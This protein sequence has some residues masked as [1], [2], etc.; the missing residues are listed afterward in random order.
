MG[1]KVILFSLMH[2]DI[3][4]FENTS[5][6]SVAA[7]M[8]NNNCKVVMCKQK[9]QHIDYEYIKKE[10]PDIIGFSVEYCILNDVIKVAAGCKE[11]LE[12]VIIFTENT[13]S[14]YNY[15]MIMKSAP[16]L[17]FVIIGEPE[18]V[19]GDVLATICEN[20]AIAL[21]E[22]IAYREDNVIKTNENYSKCKNLD[23]LPFIARDLIKDDN[24]IATVYSSKGCTGNCTF[25]EK[26]H[27]NFE[28][29]GR[30]PQNFV[31]EIIQIEET[32]KPN[33]YM[34]SDCSFDDP[35]IYGNRITE[36]C[37]KIVENNLEIY[38]CT[39]FKATFHKKANDKLNELLLQSGL[40]AVLIGIESGNED[41][42]CLYNKDATVEDNKKVI[43]YFNSLNVLIIPSF[44]C[45]NP[46]S[47]QENLIKNLTFLKSI[48][49]CARF[50]TFLDVLEYTP[51][52]KKI[53]E[54]G[55]I[56]EKNKNEGNYSYNYNYND[57]AVHQYRFK[58]KEIGV[59]AE[60][61]KQVMANLNKNYNNVFD[62]Y[63]FYLEK[64]KMH[65]K[66]ILRKSLNHNRQNLVEEVEKHFK[67]LDT[68]H[69]EF[70]GFLYEW[71][72]QLTLSTSEGVIISDLESIT[73]S[74]GISKR[75]ENIVNALNAERNKVVRK[76][77]RLD[78]KLIEQWI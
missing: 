21:I 33:I 78:K 4:M 29:R 30:S 39:S 51:I 23:E 28:W 17:D 71:L 12:N 63:L 50:L 76:I 57:N 24:K 18:M 40:I 72:E 61:L 27:F 36:I 62:D 9:A 43:E 8:R 54:A 26:K 11:I 49:Q 48:K 65:M 38:Y 32:I 20:R 69:K 25:C 15:E 16:Q 6:E 70:D 68:I 31:E 60:H 75:F 59:L 37:Q 52:Y 67:C 5:L 2:E 1:C 53:H 7:C 22:G 10:K 64:H 56:I 41:D 74:Y 66:Y 35:D 14:S 34:I 45:F 55:L 46:F 73:S 44:I 3:D 58:N 77:Y 13:Y 42:L 19:I 47:T